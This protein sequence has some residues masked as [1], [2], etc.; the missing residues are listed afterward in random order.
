MRMKSGGRELKSQSQT[1]NKIPVLKN[2]LNTKRSTSSI[3]RFSQN[4][5]QKTNSKT[6]MNYSSTRISQ[7]SDHMKVQRKQFDP[8]EVMQY[9]KMLAEQSMRILQ[10]NRINT[11]HTV[12]SGQSSMKTL[13]FNPNQTQTGPSTE[14]ETSTIHLRVK[15]A[16]RYD[17]SMMGQKGL[18]YQVQRMIPVISSNNP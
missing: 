6:I 7:Y 14:R 9:Q 16:S 2:I 17:S 18:N 5:P 12:E 13:G 15:S 3:G 8:D 4:I 1:P 11:Q 10:T